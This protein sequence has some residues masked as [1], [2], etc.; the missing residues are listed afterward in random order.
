MTALRVLI[1]C[2]RD[3][4]RRFNTIECKRPAVASHLPDQ[5]NR[6]GSHEDH[7]M[8]NRQ[9][10]SPEVLRQLLRYEQE[11]GKLFWKERGREMFSS[12]RD[13]KKW[14]TRYAGAEAFTSPS[15]G[16]R[17]GAIFHHTHRAHRVIWS[18]VHDD[19]GTMVVDHINGD[20]S[21]NRIA[22]LRLVSQQENT[23]NCGLKS[24]SRYG[25]FG[26]RK[27]RHKWNARISV[28]GRDVFLGSF[29]TLDDAL[30]AR[31]EAEAKYGYHENHG[32]QRNG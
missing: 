22:N 20:R 9:L 25:N 13:F 2:E 10:P 14:N 31:R 19:P 27:N 5:P 15:H 4:H 7:V 12:H 29:S 17:A 32:V 24:N 3:S 18:I 30:K 21:D 8:A 11:T 26:V 1:G 16:Y 23:K 6:N 28:G